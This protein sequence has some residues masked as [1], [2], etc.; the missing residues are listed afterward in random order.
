MIGDTDPTDPLMLDGEIIFLLG[1]FNNAALNS[2][3]SACDFIVAKFSRLADEQVGQVKIA[4]S[5]KA[6]GYSNLR[7]DLRRRVAVTDG[8]PYAGGISILDK[9]IQLDN[10]DR[11]KPDFT[12]D[13]MTN[14]DAP[15]AIKGTLGGG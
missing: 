15:P 4:Y 14:T 3:L 2:A 7:E 8:M 5:Q 11:V 6:K 13:Q 12:K 9:N 1:K 10:E